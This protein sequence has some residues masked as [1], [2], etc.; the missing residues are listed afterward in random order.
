MARAGN[1]G[2]YA[3]GFYDHIYWPYKYRS[4]NS[5]SICIVASKVELL[6]GSDDAKNVL[7]QL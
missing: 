5:E 1:P 2:Y 6:V 3:C 4:I 7:E